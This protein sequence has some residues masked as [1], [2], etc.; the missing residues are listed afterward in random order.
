MT[1]GEKMRAIRT[2]KGMTK[3]KTYINADIGDST[4][5]DIEKDRHMPS[6]YTLCRICY[7]LGC[8]PNDLIPE[9]MYTEDSL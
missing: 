8:T 2:S 1:L 5:N 6:L 4:Y 3:H 7:A 9:E